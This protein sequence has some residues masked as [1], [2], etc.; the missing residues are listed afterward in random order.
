MSCSCSSWSSAPSSGTHQDPDST[1]GGSGIRYD[2]DMTDTSGIEFEESRW[3]A[4]ARR[5]GYVVAV[6]VNL[7]LLFIV[8]NLL[9]W[10]VLPWLTEEFEDVLPIMNASIMASIV[11]NALYIVYDARWFKALGELVTLGFSIAVG[12]TLLRVFPFDFSAYSW[13]WE[14]TTR[15]IIVLAIV[16][17]VIAVIVN[18]ARLVNAAARHQPSGHAPV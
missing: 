11:V 9:E 12:V 15:V 3:T 2:V 17:M 5:V 8:N 4:P 14:A 16:A 6:L 13:N 10:D 1:L 7:L 18:I